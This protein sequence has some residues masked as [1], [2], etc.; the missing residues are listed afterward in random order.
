M[1]RLEEIRIELAN[2]YGCKDMIELELLNLQM[3]IPEDFEKV[4]CERYARECCI[5]TQDKILEEIE[6]DG[7]DFVLDQESITNPDNIILL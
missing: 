3:E 7:Y 6:I 1:G 2:E 5:A 4:I